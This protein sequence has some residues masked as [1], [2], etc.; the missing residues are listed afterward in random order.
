MANARAANST[1]S[2]LSTER[3]RDLVRSIL[4]TQPVPKS[5]NEVR[6]RLAALGMR[7]TQP[8]ISSDLRF[9][10]AVKTPLGY[11]TPASAQSPLHTN[12]ASA[13]ALQRALR[14]WLLDAVPASSLVVLRTGPGKANALAAELDAA[15]P[16]GVVGTLAGDDTVFVAT[17]SRRDAVRLTRDLRRQAGLRDADT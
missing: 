14:D 8:T 17:R 5:Q 6:Q 13:P 10:G 15:P 9:L 7:V 4:A 12:G 16:A 3:R 11:T 1:A 2:P